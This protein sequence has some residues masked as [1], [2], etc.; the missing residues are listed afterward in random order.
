MPEN[1]DELLTISGM[2]EEIVYKNP[3][4][5]YAVI[6]MDIDGLP[7]TVT[8]NLGDITEG[9]SLVV[10]GNYTINQKYGKQ[11]QAVTCERKLPSTRAEITRYLG[12]GIFKGIGP[13]MAKK[14]VN[15]Y[16]ENTLDIIENDPQQLSSINGITVEKALSIGNEFR[17][18]NGVR[19]IIEFLQKYKISPVTASLVW[20]DYEGESVSKVK[21][22]PYILCDTDYGVA[23]EVADNIAMDL[24][25]SMHSQSRIIAG[26][27]YILRKNA[28]EGHTCLPRQVLTDIACRFINIDEDD[29][30]KALFA[31][32]E[33]GVFFIHETVRREYVFLAEYYKAETGITKKIALMLKL[34]A[35]LEKDY[36]DDIEKIESENNIRYAL[37]QKAAINAAL[38]NNLFILTGGPGTGKTTTLNAVI[39]LFEKKKKRLTLAAPTG[40]AAKRLTDLTGRPASTIHRL[41]EV[42]FSEKNNRTRFKHCEKDPLDA[43]VIVIDE[44]SMVDVLL[45]DALLRAIKPESKLILV[46]DTHQLPSVGAGNVLRD[47]IVSKLIPTIELKEIFRQA[48]ESLIITNA[49]KIVNGE[50]PELD[51]RKKDF[52]FMETESDEKTSELVVQL[53]RTRL[54]KA[55]GLSPVDDIQVLTP[56]KKGDVGTKELNKVLQMSIN[57]PSTQKREI[58]S[59]DMVFRTGDKVMQIRNNYDVTWMRGEEKGTGIFNGDIGII[60][61]I[62]NKNS[63]LFIDFDG[64]KSVYTSDMFSDLDLAYAVTIHK[65]QGS[66]Y[67]AVIM[68]LNLYSDNLLYRNLLYTGVTRAKEL[69]IIIGRREAVS[70]MVENNKKTNRY[71]CMKAMLEENFNES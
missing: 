50:M 48:A 6:T 54:P 61:E 69:L 24:E 17:K 18:L 8:G 46:G 64:R 45:F 34:S 52:F 15:A 19:T 38:G 53:A 13:A 9:E 12:S 2:A 63:L 57:P 58:K 47:L 32:I 4:N 44:M 41:L 26:I 36:S 43:D 66:E 30:D 35:P 62:D 7:V 31:G 16:G 11:F 10:H 42:E 5:G 23:F 60:Y 55:Y 20:N 14:I 29:L 65:S 40:R 37:E 56:T 27:E 59:S 39:R 28:L 25:L 21:E 3:S 33:K 70:K 1:T 49:H 67:R 68:P 71:S 22:D 51:E